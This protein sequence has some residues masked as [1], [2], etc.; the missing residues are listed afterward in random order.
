MLA[1]V[2]VFHVMAAAIA[3]L[4]CYR[5]P[6]LWRKAEPELEV[7]NQCLVEMAKRF[8]T[9]LGAQR[10]VEDL[11]RAVTQQEQH[12]GP[13]HLAFSTDQI[14]YFKPLGPEL[15]SQWDLIFLN[16]NVPVVSAEISSQQTSGRDGRGQNLSK[17]G[18]A[19]EQDVVLPSSII[20]RDPCHNRGALST[21]PMW[22]GDNL[23][24]ET[25]LDALLQSNEELLR[26]DGLSFGEFDNVGNWM[27]DDWMTDII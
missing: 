20:L 26:Q 17:F 3:Q 11:S 10:V 5:Y 16:T 22:N 21:A 9:A 18:G 25:D 2:F 23:R 14:K 24:T 19:Q 12:D 4:V 8:P 1:S 6:V 15:C 7:F 13:L 27:L